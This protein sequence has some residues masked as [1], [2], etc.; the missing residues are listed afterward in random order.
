MF[1]DHNEMSPSIT[2]VKNWFKNE[3]KL[4]HKVMLRFWYKPSLKPDLPLKPKFETKVL[5]SNQT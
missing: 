3:V 5:V 4:K 2:A 1:S